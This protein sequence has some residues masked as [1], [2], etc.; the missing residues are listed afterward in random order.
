MHKIDRISQIRVIL[1]QECKQ[2][3]LLGLDWIGCMHTPFPHYM[4]V[5]QHM[6]NVINTNDTFFVTAFLI[7]SLDSKPILHTSA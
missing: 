5:N 3:N 1:P 6:S 4:Y 7:T 2:S